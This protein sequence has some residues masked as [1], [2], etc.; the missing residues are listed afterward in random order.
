MPPSGS[1]EAEASNTVSSPTP[2]CL[3]APAAATGG[4]LMVIRWRAETSWQVGE[5]ESLFSVSAT[6]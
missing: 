5:G 3:S 6:W 4:A 1:F 2:M